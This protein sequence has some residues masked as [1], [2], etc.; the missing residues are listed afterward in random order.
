M[1][2]GL[3][4][5]F[6]G[7]DGCGKTTQIKL[8][9]EYLRSKGY[10]VVLT[11]TDD[12]FVSLEDRVS[13]SEN[14]KPE[15]FVSIHVNSA[16]SNDP[17]GYETH[18]YHDN[19]KHLAEKIQ[20]N[21]AKELP[22]ANDRGLFKSKFYVINHTTAPAVLCEIGFISNDNE[23]NELITNSRKQKT[24]KAISEG[25]IEFLKTQKR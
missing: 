23:R 3:F 25:I 11:R 16:T 21:F 14:E 7:G 9:D 5:T 19:G 12:T 10:K 22:N 8:L 1:S 4:I 18:W 2:K 13:I 24:A 20:R 6:E 17:E 15:V